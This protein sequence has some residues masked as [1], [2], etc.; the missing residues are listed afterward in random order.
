VL[1][2]FAAHIVLVNVHENIP[3]QFAVSIAGIVIMMI[4]GVALSRAQQ[5]ASRQRNLA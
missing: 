2:S 3:V 4:V 5:V 1:L